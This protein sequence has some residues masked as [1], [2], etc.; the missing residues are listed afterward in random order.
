[1]FPLKHRGYRTYDFCKFL[2]E[3]VLDPVLIFPDPVLSVLQ[4][5]GN[6][7]ISFN[8]QRT[9]SRGS[10]TVDISRYSRSIDS[11]Q[12]ICN[13]F[14]YQ[15]HFA[16]NHGSEFNKFLYNFVIRYP[17]ALGMRPLTVISG[18]TSHAALLR[19][20]TDLLNASVTQY[21]G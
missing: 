8:Y 15:I 6:G 2:C 20:A 3:L 5:A 4:I 18:D 21:I 11:L 13:F 7:S 10:G 9:G 17:S 12:R 16:L 1:M 19:C 14:K